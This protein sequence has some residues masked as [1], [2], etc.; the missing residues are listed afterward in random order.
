MCCLHLC[1]PTLAMHD[2]ISPAQVSPWAR[3]IVTRCFA[4]VPTIA[5]ALLMDPASTELD[6]LNQVWEV[7][8]VACGL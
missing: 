2:L 3:I 6:K 7:G 1:P 8:W 5:V 4:L